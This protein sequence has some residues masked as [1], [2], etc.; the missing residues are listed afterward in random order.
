MAEI[1]NLENDFTSDINK[2]APVTSAG[3]VTKSTP[4]SVVAQVATPVA[5]S[6][7]EI[8]ATPVR[9]PEPEAVKPS[10]LA[11]EKKPVT[12]A[13]MPHSQAQSNVSLAAAG[14]MALNLT[15]K[16]G[17][18]DATLVID[19][20]KG[21]LVSFSGVELSLHSENGCS[22]EMAN[23]VYFSVPLDGK[24]QNKKKIA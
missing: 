6:A 18:K 16:I 14:N 11:F 17:D 23:G 19:Q 2:T 4:A 10:V 9:S 5:A 12:T 15:F 22:I 13:A 3:T 20:E 7:P 8:I 21:L 24:V 1:D